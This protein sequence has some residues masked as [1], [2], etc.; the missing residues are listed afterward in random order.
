MTKP[1]AVTW[2]DQ[3]ESPLPRNI[4]RDPT[5]PDHVAAAR[6]YECAAALNDAIRAAHAQELI[7]DLE[8]VTLRGAVIDLE[9]LSVQVMKRL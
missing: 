6:I 8:I 5:T 1:D 2:H 3:P 7:V 9:T 4:A